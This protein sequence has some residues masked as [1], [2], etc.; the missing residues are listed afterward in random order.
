MRRVWL[1]LLSTV[2]PLAVHCEDRPL[3]PGGMVMRN[4][5]VN[6]APCRYEHDSSVGKVLQ[7][8]SVVSDPAK[9]SR[10]RSTAIVELRNNSAKTITAYI[11]NRTFIQ[12]GKTTYYGTSGADLVYEMALAK[13]SQEQVSPNSTFPPGGVVHEEISGGIGHGQFEV[14]PC[15][16]AFEDG[17]FIGPRSEFELL[18]Q[19]RAGSAKEFAALVADL[20]SAQGSSDPK[21]F[22]A[23]R[24]KHI[25]RTSTGRLAEEPYSYLQ[26]VASSLSA[27]GNTPLDRKTI[28]EHISGL[29]AEQE[30]LVQQST[31]GKTK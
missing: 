9:P 28:T 5:T 29:Q 30:M 17:T 4:F 16:V 10:A 2:V 19:M 20:K 13:A 21:T 3:Q 27:S 18:V 7:I 31:F 26:V 15:M 8:V 25:K 1:I 11:F 12:G 14:Y 23:D 6:D 24:A 22:L